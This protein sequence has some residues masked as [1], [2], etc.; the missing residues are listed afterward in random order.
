M[1]CDKG[2]H[3][4]DRQSPPGHSVSTEQDL[5]VGCCAGVIETHPEKTVITHAAHS[6]HA[7]APTHRI[8]LL[9]M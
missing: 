6:V 2:E 3:C 5:A 7:I 9:I 8:R 1:G 4:P